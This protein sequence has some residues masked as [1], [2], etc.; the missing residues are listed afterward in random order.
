[1]EVY[2][3]DWKEASGWCAWLEAVE[4]IETEWGGVWVGPGVVEDARVEG[5]ELM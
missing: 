5:R 3:V 1:L 4:L 2:G